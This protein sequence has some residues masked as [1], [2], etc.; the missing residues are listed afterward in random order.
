MIKSEQC[1]KIGCMI[2][3]IKLDE[4]LQYTDEYCRTN[5]PMRFE[6]AERF[7]F[8]ADRLRC[9]GAGI[10]LYECLGL[11]D[12]DIYIDEYDKPHSKAFGRDF[13]IT[14]SGDYVALAWIS[15]ET[16]NAGDSLRIGIDIE[17]IEERNF[18]FAKV[19]YCQEELDWLES[20][21]SENGVPCGSYADRF[22]SLWTMKESVSK[23]VGMGLS[24]DYKTFNA[25]QLVLDGRMTLFGHEFTAESLDSIG[26]CTLEGY[27]AS[28]CVMR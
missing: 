19:V 15:D 23:A 8:D 6:K 13:S 17:K 5:F 22:Y 14:H 21:K 25:L 28:V 16:L 27:A 4:V 18:D 20:L 9:L 1:E 26:S 24:I 10:L 12:G 3:L 2:G 11:E 7:V